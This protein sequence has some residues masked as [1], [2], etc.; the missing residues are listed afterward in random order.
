[1]SSV[2]PTGP[3]SL[4]PPVKRERTAWRGLH[5]ALTAPAGHM[6]GRAAHCPCPCSSYDLRGQEPPRWRKRGRR[7]GA[8]ALGTAE[9]PL[10][11]PVFPPTSSSPVPQVSQLSSH[12][13]LTE[14][15]STK[16]ALANRAI[17]MALAPT[18]AMT[19]PKARLAKGLFLLSSPQRVS[20]APKP[21]PKV[22]PMESAASRG[23]VHGGLTA[24]KS[25]LREPPRLQHGQAGRLGAGW[26]PAVGRQPPPLH[27]PRKQE[28][29][30]GKAVRDVAGSGGA[31]SARNGEAPEP[32]PCARQSPAPP[33]GHHLLGAQHSRPAS[34]TEAASL[35]LGIRTEMARQGA[36]RTAGRRGTKS[37]LNRDSKNDP[38]CIK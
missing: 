31:P 2:T 34:G 10:F 26:G 25:G 28:P 17:V 37:M 6:Q 16:P 36:V 5:E 8:G 13:V 4:V 29:A 9:C 27:L 21:N 23:H 35:A 11:L 19:R 24:H 12:T 32:R 14:A 3:A 20:G 33:R 22:K 18:T 38:T 1:M 30:L 7:V 15:P